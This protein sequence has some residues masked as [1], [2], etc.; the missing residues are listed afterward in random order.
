MYVTFNN[1]FEIAETYEGKRR[2]HYRHNLRCNLKMFIEKTKPQTNPALP[3]P[4]RD[5]EIVMEGGNQIIL[6]EFKPKLAGDLAKYLKRRT[7]KSAGDLSYRD[8]ERLAA[9]RSID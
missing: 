2:V 6:K 1:R 9:V 5:W 4:D 3:P 8:I 7:R